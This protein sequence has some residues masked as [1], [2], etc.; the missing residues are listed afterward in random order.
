MSKEDKKQKIKDTALAGASL[1]ALG[2]SKN[3]ILGKK[4]MYHGTSKEN[5]EKIRTSPDAPFY[6][7]FFYSRNILTWFLLLTCLATMCD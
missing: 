5:W 3:M 6:F 4:K 1:G 7:R 2:A